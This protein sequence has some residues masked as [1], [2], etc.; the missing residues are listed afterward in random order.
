MVHKKKHLILRQPKLDSIPAALPPPTPPPPMN[1]ER[2]PI[3]KLCRKIIEAETIQI[4]RL[5]SLN[6][7][8]FDLQI[9]G[10]CRAGNMECK[11]AARWVKPYRCLGKYIRKYRAHALQRK[12]H[13]YISFLGIAR[14]QPQFQHSCVCERFV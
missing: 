3:G 5:F 10:W 9:G 6:Y 8:F 12:Y 14:P 1:R 11:G 7:I 2:A 13:I 4:F